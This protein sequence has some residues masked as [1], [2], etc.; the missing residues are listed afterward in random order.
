MNIDFQE[1]NAQYASEQLHKSIELLSECL[2][3][4]GRRVSQMM[5]DTINQITARTILPFTNI[6]DEEKEVILAKE[7]IIEQ[8]EQEELYKKYNPDNLF[9]NKASKVETVENS[10][11]MVEYKESFFTKIKNWF[12][13]IF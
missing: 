1:L 12:K 11:S 7:K 4:M 6:A 10:V 9:K 3:E 8:K 13:R 5:S 2:D